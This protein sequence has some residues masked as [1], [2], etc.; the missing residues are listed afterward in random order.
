[1]AK[2]HKSAAL[3]SLMLIAVGV[4]AGFCQAADAPVADANPPGPQAG[5]LI[6]A[7]GSP[8]GEW[9]K[10]VADLEQAVKKGLG[11]D[12]G[13]SVVRVVFMEFSQP[14][15]ADGVKECE[16]AGCRRIIAVP[17]L[18]APSSHS[19]WD[20]PALLGLY[21]NAAM[22][23]ELIKE[24]ARIIRSDLPITLT[25]TIEDSGLIERI[26]LKRVAE[27]SKD[28]NNEAIVLLA[29]GD[30]VTSPLWDKLMR[31]TTTFICGRMGISYGDWIY[32]G[33]GQSYDKA[34]SAI[35]RAGEYRKRIIVAGAY[36]SM[37]VDTMH[38]RWLKQFHSASGATPGP[39]NPLKDLDVVL[40]EAGV[41]PD[42][43]VSQWIVDVSKGELA[44]TPGPAPR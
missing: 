7:H 3:A 36:L 22:E 10:P 32:A 21:G 14:S 30:D 35:A 24:G 28:P 41:L 11:P 20:I 6:V 4:G 9:N 31:R 38:A 13:F 39:E 40:C 44:R 42:P 18:I 43:S 16:L 26:M 17:L 15:V 33:V 12:S 19:L 27:L 2:E 8:S 1:M 5:L 25:A 34:V 29:H 23:E 37:G